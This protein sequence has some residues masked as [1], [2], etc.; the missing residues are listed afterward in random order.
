MNDRV[1]FID[2]SK[3]IGILMVVYQHVLFALIPNALIVH[4]SYEVITS[5]H[6][7]LFF[8]LSG[9]FWS[10]KSDLKSFV[11]KKIKTLLI[12]FGC[13]YIFTSY[14]LGKL[15]QIY[16]IS[17]SNNECNWDDFISKES[18]PNGPIWFLLSLFIACCYYY[19]INRIGRKWLIV[20]FLS[21]TIGF[22]GYLCFRLNVN[23]PMFLDTSMVGCLFLWIGNAMG[24][25][26]LLS[27]LNAS[28]WLIL[29]LGIITY[30]CAP[31][32]VMMVNAYSG[33][34]LVFVL[35]SITG[36]LFVSIMSKKISCDKLNYYGRYSII[37]L[38]THNVIVSLGSLLVKKVTDI[39]LIQFL[40]VFASVIILEYFVIYLIRNYIPF[41]VGLS[42]VS[43]IK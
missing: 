43:E 5:F 38:C 22:G 3:G 35:T 26:N 13:F 20:S 29:I 41:V 39:F 30:L 6:M 1:A 23:L 33:S 19:V 18:F 36:T 2:T 7:P 37:I 34:F 12:P 28:Y 15:A 25:V 42:K 11:S 4:R 14:G 16:G 10:N 9:Y 32:V 17:L 24:K 31:Y 8:I 40:C 27:K 21:V